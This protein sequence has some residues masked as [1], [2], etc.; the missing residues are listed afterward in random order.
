MVLTYLLSAVRYC[1][2]FLG[3]D[4]DW[5]EEDRRIAHEAAQRLF[6]DY[7]TFV[8]EE[9]PQNYVT[10]VDVDDDTVE[11][12]IHPYYQRNIAASRKYRD[13]HDGGKQ[14]AVGSYVFDPPSKEWQHHVTLYPTADGRT[15]VYSHTE[16]S[17]REGFDHLSDGVSKRGNEKELFTLLNKASVSYGPRRK[18]AKAARNAKKFN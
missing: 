9:K 1:E 12:I 2:R 16:T 6:G 8:H 11:Q 17:V 18:L 5:I 14:W 13:H 10:T 15:D 4:D 3:P 7:H